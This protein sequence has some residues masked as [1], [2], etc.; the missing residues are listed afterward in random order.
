MVINCRVESKD[1]SEG[2]VIFAAS[3]LCKTPRD[4]VIGN[5]GG[6]YM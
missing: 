5:S 3:L 6:S 2:H 1:F 4:A